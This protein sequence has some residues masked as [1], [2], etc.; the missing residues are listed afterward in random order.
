MASRRLFDGA[1][2]EIGSLPIVGAAG[3]SVS[4]SV[5][6]VEATGALG[7][8]TVA[9]TGG[10]VTVNVTGVAATSAAGTVSVV[11]RANTP[12]TG[13]G[14]TGQLG[15]VNVTTGGGSVIVNATGVSG[16]GAVGTLAS[17]TGGASVY[18]T[19]VSGFGLTSSALVWGPVNESQTP[20]WQPVVDGNTVVWVEIPT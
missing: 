14:S 9:T 5:T 17:D 2:A 12:V 8:L 15:T 20:N 3:Q 7:T 18:P 19:G 13:V 6:G 10:A 16:T 11:A 4:V 1:Q